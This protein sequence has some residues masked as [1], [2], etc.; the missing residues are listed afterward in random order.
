[1]AEYYAQ[2]ALEIGV[3]M[4]LVLFLGGTAVRGLQS[5]R[6]AFF[7]VSQHV[8]ATTLVKFDDPSMTYLHYWLTQENDRSKPLL[9]HSYDATSALYLDDERGVRVV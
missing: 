6:K 5:E 4:A 3:Q 9:T 1:M 8:E 7:V 2:L